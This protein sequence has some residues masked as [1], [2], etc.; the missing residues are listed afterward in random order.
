MIKLKWKTDIEKEY[1]K[2]EPTYK[3]TVYRGDETCV[4]MMNSKETIG[5]NLWSM[6]TKSEPLFDEVRITLATEEEIKEW[7]SLPF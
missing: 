3:T 2:S 6:L 1:E 4:E 7:D 5:F